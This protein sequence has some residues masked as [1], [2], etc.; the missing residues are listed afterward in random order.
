MGASV[1]LTSSHGS[2]VAHG[3]QDVLTAA[4]G[5]P[6]HIGRVCAIGASIT[7][8]QYFERVPRTFRTSSFMAPKDLEQLT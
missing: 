3:R 2:F 1:S 4:I 8:K 6:E 5:R 7:I